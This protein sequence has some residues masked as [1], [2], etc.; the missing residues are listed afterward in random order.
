MVKKNK[1]KQ[2]GQFEFITIPRT[3]HKTA[4]KMLPEGFVRHATTRAP[5]VDVTYIT[6]DGKKL[7]SN[8]DAERY[9]K[10]KPAYGNISAKDFDFS[11]TTKRKRSDDDGGCA[12]IAERNK[13]HDAL[14]AGIAERTKLQE[15]LD[16]E[17]TKHE[18]KMRK[19][20][21]VIEKTTLDRQSVYESL[22]DAEDKLVVAQDDATR[23]AEQVECQ[24]ALIIAEQTKV[25]EALDAERTKN[26]EVVVELKQKLASALRH[27]AQQDKERASQKIRYEEVIFL[28]EKQVYSA[29]GKAAP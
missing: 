10:G 18:E 6:P 14:D 4:D 5:R 15:A 2:I 11:S 3:Q 19:M 21:R 8:P 12:R 13:L 23:L 9:L 1:K 17:R 27:S 20:R 25:W 28:L 26:D 22:K 7:R 16:A 24:K 29:E